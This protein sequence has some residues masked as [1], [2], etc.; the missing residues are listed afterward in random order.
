MAFFRLKPV[1][2]FLGV[3][4][5]LAIAPAQNQ[6]L[7]MNEPVDLSPDFKDYLN[8]Y[9]FTDSLVSFN[10]ATGEGRI[11]WQ[12]MRYTPAHAFN[13]TQHGFRPMQQNEFPATEYEEDPI[14]PFSLQFVDSRTVR[15]QMNTGTVISKNEPSLML[16]G[17][18]QNRIQDWVYTAIPRGHQYTSPHGKVI[19]RQKPWAVEFYDATGTLL[20]KT[21]HSSDNAGFCANMPFAFVRRA[22]DYSRSVGAVFEL[23]PDEKI[24]GCGESF[25]NL[26]KYGQKVN[27]YTCDPNGVE[28]PGMYKPIPFF[29][30]S[31]GYGM[32]MHTSSPITC[33]FG[34]TYGATNKLL[35]G[36]ES[37]DLFVF[38]GQPKD[39][40]DAYTDLTGKAPM[41]PLWSFGLWMSRITYFSEADGRNVAAKLRANKIPTDVLHFDTGWFETDWRC[42]YEF[43][44]SRF[45]DPQKMIA[46]LKADGF[47]TCLWQLPYFV[48]QNKLF[49]EI[50]QKGL[51]VRNAK[52]NIPFE[53]AVLDFT[54]PETVDWYSQKIGDLLKMGV[55][56]I[57]VDF[58]EA[59]PYNGLYAN[60][61]T[62]FYEHN[63]YPLRYNQTVSNLTKE[64]NGEPII[65]ARSAWA[66]SQRY[67]LH[68]GGDAES[69]DMG[70]EAQ[71]RG[72]LSLGVSGFTFWSH[73]IGGFTKRTPE[74]LYRRWL[75]FGVLSSHTRCHGQPPKEPWDYGDDFQNYFRKVV[76]MKYQLMPY[77]YAQSK[78]A[79][80][81]GLPMVR[82]L[83]VEYP[84]DPG[85]WEVE[86]AYLFGENMMVAP[87]FE[88]GKTERA[89]YL[90]GGEWVDYQTGKTYSKG[91]H[92]IAVGEIEAIILVKSGTI[93]PK[94]QVA[95]STD[96]MDWT[97]IELSVYGSG[98]Q[99]SGWLCL[100][101]D[102]ILRE[103]KMV[104]QGKKWQMQAGDWPKEVRWKVG[105]ISNP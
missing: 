41:P 58:G 46:D 34:N 55:S 56:V 75:P 96:Q 15:L 64:I 16:V 77:V 71:L 81:K 48:P 60:G 80:E 44:K 100:P 101:G 62:G 82:A 104:R 45:E 30:S 18:P 13:F 85:A 36:D 87:I 65:W 1:I 10:P 43:A 2:S 42:D 38:L 4:F 5:L 47:R 84:E 72:G 93:L 33:D 59:A 97:N 76:E 91:W 17:E 89:V 6:Q 102:Q 8:T 23:S 26:N 31:R 50:I 73:D 94:I 63:L 27:L 20:T 49:P 78:I 40:L 92:T 66:G 19:V 39:I 70:M 24:F 98:K 35:I 32:F 105:F 3:F 67:P 69:S 86:N 57:K 25:T 53:D 99:A 22:A 28:T 51:H 103:I 83:F 37:L 61:R 9:F 21:R 14:M 90:P 68:W 11:N 52:G 7:L 74:N 79:S 95:Q 12:R 29:L 88:E 54:N